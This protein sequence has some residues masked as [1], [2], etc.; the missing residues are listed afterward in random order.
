MIS[1]C[2]ESICGYS[3]K[4]RV[5]RVQSELCSSIH[6]RVI[7]VKLRHVQMKNCTLSKRHKIS[8]YNT[9]FTKK[10]IYIKHLILIQYMV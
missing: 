2:T 4:K 9:K 8:H 5:F 7:E 3:L 6:S 1:K 10:L